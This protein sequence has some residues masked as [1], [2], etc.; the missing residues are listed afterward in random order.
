MF[1][2]LLVM[3]GWTYAAVRL[4]H[5]RR[6]EPAGTLPSPPAVPEPWGRLDDL[7]LTRLLRQAARGKE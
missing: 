7:Q 3:A 2:L 4:I 1:I 6:A 5:A